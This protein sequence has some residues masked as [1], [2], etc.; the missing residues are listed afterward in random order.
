MNFD[1]ATKKFK[2]DIPMLPWNETVILKGNN[3][4]FTGCIKISNVV[5]E[6][7]L[8]KLLKTIDSIELQILIQWSG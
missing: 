4:S 2:I 7:I 3:R 8:F 5:D 1:V 6:S